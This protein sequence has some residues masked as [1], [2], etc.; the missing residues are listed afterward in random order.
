MIIFA[1]LSAKSDEPRQIA[2]GDG[3]IDRGKRRQ[4]NN[5]YYSICWRE[6]PTTVAFFARLITIILCAIHLTILTTRNHE[7]SH[8][9]LK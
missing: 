3:W 9:S 4:G 2:G 1:Y 8:F 6:K 5:Y 7:F